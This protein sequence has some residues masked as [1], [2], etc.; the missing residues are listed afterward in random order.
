VSAS[1]AR[2]DPGYAHSLVM[3]AQNGGVGASLARA[4]LS[5]DSGAAALQP[6]LVLQE[7][8]LLA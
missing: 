6:L 2:D 1:F 3:N 7:E 5:P 4:P 8:V